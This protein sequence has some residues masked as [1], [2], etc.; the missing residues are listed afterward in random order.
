MQFEWTAIQGAERYEIELSNDIDMVVFTHED[1]RATA[2]PMPKDF[3]L[4]PGTYYW[5]ITAV[6]GG[7]LVGDSGRSAFVVRE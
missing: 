5:R 3:T 4:M 2:L 1:V 7:R 6:R